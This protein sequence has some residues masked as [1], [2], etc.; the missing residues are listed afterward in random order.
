MLTPLRGITTTRIVKTYILLAL[1]LLLRPFGNLSLA[2]GM[3]HLSTVVSGSPFYCLAAMLNPYVAF[4][5]L[6]LIFGLLTR[7]ALLSL[8]DLSF[9]VPLTAVGSIFATVLGKYVLR[10]QITA[11]RWAGTLLVFVGSIVISSTHKEA[12]LKPGLN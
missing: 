4:G 9:V 6:L 11:G 10:E 7:M 3:R 1:T 12:T 8:A 2:W 5:M